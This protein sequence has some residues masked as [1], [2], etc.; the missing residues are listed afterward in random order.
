MVVFIYIKKIKS[1]TDL[2]NITKWQI[3]H[4]V[5]YV[6]SRNLDI[7]PDLGPYILRQ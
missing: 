1:F 4:M 5:H 7:D 3:Q 2:N 6:E